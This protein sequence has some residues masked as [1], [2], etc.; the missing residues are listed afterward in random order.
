MFCKSIWKFSIVRT[1]EEEPNTR[2]KPDV[3]S[4]LST[5]IRSDSLHDEI[6]IRKK[7]LELS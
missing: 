4:N 3:Q 7:V 2:A 5:C 1:L 6:L